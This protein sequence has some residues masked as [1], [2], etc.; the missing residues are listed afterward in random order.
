METIL[1]FE[2][3]SKKIDNIYKVGHMSYHSMTL[4]LI[5]LYLK[6]QK[7][8]YTESKTFC[9]V[10]LYALMLPAILISSVC[11]VI[12]VPLKNTKNGNVVVSALNGANSFL[13]A[14]ITYMKLDAKA[15]AHKTT[16]YQFDKLQ[17]MC[18]FYSGKALLLKDKEL[19]KH[20]SEFI[21][22]LEKKVG[23]IKDANQFII[24]ES[25]RY[26]YNDIYSYNV[27]SIMK[28]YKTKRILNVQR[29]LDVT[30]EILKKS[31]EENIEVPIYSYPLIKKHRRILFKESIFREKN[32]DPPEIDYSKVN[33]YDSKT[34]LS[35]LYSIKDTCIRDIIKY[36]NVSSD[37]NK[38]FNIQ[39]E[40]NIQ[41]ERNRWYWF[42]LKPNWLKT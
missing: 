11:T 38:E 32:D 30:T 27:F 4:D 7:I 26:K 18:D 6:G 17:T 40:Q 2:K 23:E 28:E 29:L 37:L 24:P 19:E 12:N 31:H 10:L 36:R 34:T 21:H 35:D 9:E 39:I 33:M 20:V 3:N 22:L 13:L 25:V 8:L 41:S 1:N 5:G 42:A 16:A 14:V 15:E